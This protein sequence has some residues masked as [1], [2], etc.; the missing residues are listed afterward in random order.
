MPIPNIDSFKNDL[1]CDIWKENYTNIFEEIMEK[2]D[3]EEY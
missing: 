2:N 3:F 1:C